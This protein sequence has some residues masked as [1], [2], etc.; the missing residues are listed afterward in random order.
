M[1]GGLSLGVAPE[2]SVLTGYISQA[3]LAA[4]SGG[5]WTVA[6][7]IVLVSILA[8]VMALLGYRLMLP[9]IF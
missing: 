6:I 9:L 3:N 1:W 2:H 8:T 4:L 5:T 7:V